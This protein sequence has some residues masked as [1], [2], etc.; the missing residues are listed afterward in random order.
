[1]LRLSTNAERVLASRYLR[2]DR[3]GRIVESPDQLF[4]RVSRSIADAELLTG[5][6]RQAEVWLEEFH[7]LL[8]SFDFL[9][10]SPT[11]MNAG[12]PLGQL[13]A[14]FVLPIEDT[15]EGI[16][17]ALKQMALVQRTGGGTGFSFSR[18]RPKGDI[19]ASTGGQAS[20]PVSFMNIF[21]CATE[22]IKQGGK[23]RGAN[24][25]I[26]RVD[27]PDILEF[28]SA[29]REGTALENFNISVGA[30]DVFMEA[31]LTDSSYNLIH[32]RTGLSIRRHAAKKVFDAIA[33]SAW[34]T[35][36]PGMI[37]LD[38]INSANPTPHLGAIDATNP[39]GEIPLLPYES[40]NLGSINLAH[41]LADNNGKATVD[42]CK[43]ATTVQKAVRFLDNVITVNK[44]SLPEIEHMTH[45]NRKIGLGVMGFADMLIQ[46]GCSYDSDEAV[47]LAEQL[48]RFIS[49][50][51]LQ[52]SRELA[53]ERGLF[54]NWKGSVYQTKQIEVR[55]ATR[56]AVAP[57]GT[58]SIIAATSASI[59][60]LFALAYRRSHVLRD[61]TLYEVNPI[62][63]KHLE[64][65][66]MDVEKALE[67]IE[68]EGHIRNVEDLPEE[69]R[70]LFVTALDIAPERHLQIQAAFQRH[71]DNSV[72][73]TINL[74]A[75][76]TPGEI[77]RAYR[78]AWEWRLKGVTIY[79]YGSKSKQV[80]ELGVD[81]EAFYYDHSS[82]CDP[83][84]CKI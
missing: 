52:A 35:G 78:L 13:S 66:G 6:G 54:P 11:L 71:V 45:G 27:H 14:C 30:T 18:L 4:E 19:V 65:H 38:T 16:F 5:N 49:E 2:R 12:T 57:T 81:E 22:N 15:M 26:L 23:R 37:F 68:E 76:A 3:E 53:R 43:L 58:I 7:S 41:M 40:C 77:A 20:G 67:R 55:N 36:D 73:K 60:P 70:R 31:V 63:V 21:D 44:F 50:R 1:M 34:L 82:S 62:L 48:M 84:E 47:G 59:E 9:P 33:E 8:T 56:T 72:S 39:C 79:R 28:I 83:R 29:K 80:L 25:G 17:E 42:W 51:A 69:I 74:P 64:R 32:P 46:V 61:E 10:N 24:M 75:T